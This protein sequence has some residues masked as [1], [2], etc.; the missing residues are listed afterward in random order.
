M[1]LT[2]DRLVWLPICV[3]CH[4]P[5]ELETCKTDERGRAVHEECYVRE[6]RSTHRSLLLA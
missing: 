6:I 2:S 5:V 4:S 1:S 3:L